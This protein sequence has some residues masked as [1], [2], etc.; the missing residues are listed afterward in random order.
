MST[1]SPE[2]KEKIREG[3][4]KAINGVIFHTMDIKDEADLVDDLCFDSID[5]TEMVVEIEQIYGID[6]SDND[7]KKMKTVNDV[8][9][10]VSKILNTV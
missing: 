3:V 6:I 2:G 10:C 1:I 5:T 8:V 4:Y 9:E 7:V